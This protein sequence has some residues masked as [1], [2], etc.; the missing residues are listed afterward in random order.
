MSNTKIQIKRSSTTALPSD[1]S[2]R[3]G[4]LAYSYQSNLLYL[5]TANGAKI[6]VIGGKFL[7]DHANAAFDSANTGSANLYTYINVSTGSANSWANA[8]GDAANAWANAVGTAGNSYAEAVGTAGNNWVDATFVKLTEMAGQTVTGDLSIAGNL[9][10]TG[11]TTYA[12]T[13]TL[14]IGDNIFVLNADLPGGSAP[15]QDAGMEIN[16]GTDPSVS[17]LWNEAQDAWTFTN[18]GTNFYQISS[19]TGRIDGLAAGNAW[20]NTV[21]ASANLWANAV[22]TAGNSY[23]DFV[24]ASG[25]LWANAVGTA[26]NNYTIAVGAAANAWANAVGVAGNAYADFVGSIANTN[27]AN[28][29]YISTGTVSVLFGGT[30]INYANVNGVIF[31]NGTGPFQVTAA[32]SEGN[33]LQV[34]DVG[35]PVFDMLDGGVF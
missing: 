27:A 35:V 15:S 20:S 6:D 5:G 12:N 16:R 24:G 26:G 23:A 29:S 2:L 28:G 30:G 13:Q 34:N 25:N 1:G 33:V 21:S 22:G 17:I 32:G 11:V 14:N 4:E 8:V 31:G 18:D 9:T 3:A 19:N 7:Y 10:I